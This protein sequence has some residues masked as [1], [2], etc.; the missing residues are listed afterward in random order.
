MVVARE[1]AGSEEV[2]V[3]ADLVAVVREAV[4]SGEAMV[5]AD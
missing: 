3:A 2:T 1:A 5:V 4:G